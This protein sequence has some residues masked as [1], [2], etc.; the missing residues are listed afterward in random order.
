[1]QTGGE[2]P[3]SSISLAF[4]RIF[5]GLGLFYCHPSPYLPILRYG[6]SGDAGGSD[7]GVI[8]YVCV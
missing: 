2:S 1:M 5:G 3:T 8:G 6:S 4:C 7:I